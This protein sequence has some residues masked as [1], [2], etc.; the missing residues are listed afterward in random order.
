MLQSRFCQQ[1]KS[2]R[3]ERVVCIF[4]PPLFQIRLSTSK[5]QEIH[6]DP[7][8][9]AVHALIQADKRC[10]NN[11]PRYLS[12]VPS[13]PIKQRVSDLRGQPSARLL[14]SPGQ[15]QALTCPPPAGTGDK[16]TASASSMLESNFDARSQRVSFLK[17]F[18]K[19]TQC[20]G[21]NTVEV[22]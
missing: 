13:E 12:S 10:S 1:K 8:S 18:W 17:L 6:C 3:R 11:F 14:I 22:C 15:T 9:F 5:Q 19:P 4:F 7:Q 2:R 20:E 21:L 16:S